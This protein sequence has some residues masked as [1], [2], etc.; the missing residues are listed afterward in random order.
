MRVRRRWPA[1]P[2]KQFPAALFCIVLAGFSHRKTIR[3]VRLRSPVN[4]S[5]NGS[6][7]ST[8]PKNCKDSPKSYDFG[9]SLA[10]HCEIAF[11]EKHCGSTDSRLSFALPGFRFQDTHES[12]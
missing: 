3:Y 2:S 8:G 4:G 11:F 10:C 12:P 6:E 5:L 7:K 1:I 9:E